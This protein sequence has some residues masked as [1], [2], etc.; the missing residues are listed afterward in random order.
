MNGT[1]GRPV[2]VT[3]VPDRVDNGDRSVRIKH[4]AT[5]GGYDGVTAER[6]VTI[7]DNDTAGLSLGMP[8]DDVVVTE[9][10][11]NPVTIT[12]ALD[13]EPTSRVTVTVSST[14]TEGV[15]VSKTDKG[16]SA[17]SSISLTFTSDTWDIDQTVYVFGVDNGIEETD[18]RSVDVS[19]TANGVGY[20]SIMKTAS[21]RVDADPADNSG[22]AISDPSPD[23]TEGAALP[24]MYTVTLDK[25]P[26][27]RVTVTV[28]STD[29]KG[30]KV[31]KTKEG[32]PA[33]RPYR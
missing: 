9:G 13:S 8:S 26:T 2:T 1:T 14:D 25:V 18:F 7:R 31:S 12:V 6:T 33:Q 10:I 19:F 29:T 32:P 17:R 5:G 24:S 3:S 30:A 28:S 27:N 22:M 21:V 4:V 16:T 11:P 15:K 23:I 20:R